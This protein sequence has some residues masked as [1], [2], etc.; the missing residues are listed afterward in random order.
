MTGDDIDEAIRRADPARSVRDDRSEAEKT[1]ALHRITSTPR[2]P[3]RVRVAS[4]WP[5]LALPVAAAAVASLVIVQTL[6]PVTPAAA[7][8]PPMLS[9]SSISQTTDEVLDDAIARLQAAP[10]VEPERRASYEGWYL[11]TDVDGTSSVSAISPQRHELAWQEDLSGELTVTAGESYTVT[12]GSTSPVTDDTAPPAGSTLLEEQ[13]GAGEM[14]VLFTTPPPTDIDEMRSYLAL[15]TGAPANDS[16]GYI[17]GARV[18]LNEWTLGPQHQAALLTILRESGD[19]EVLGD[20]TDRLGRP[21]IALRAAS[22]DQPNFELL[23]LLSRDSGALIG[24][25]AVYLGGLP[26][27]GVDPPCVTEYIAWK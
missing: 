16:V 12:D 4:K 9:V 8:T 24:L 10:D 26:E 14:P 23:A 21:A 19:L 15:A 22:P 18:L 1:A 2:V 27:L 13:Y 17:L 7:A 25:E 20:V 3:A 5:W 11:Q 6:Q